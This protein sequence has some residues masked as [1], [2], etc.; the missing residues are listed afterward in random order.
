MT[1]RQDWTIMNA[2]APEVVV[3]SGFSAPLPPPLFVP[4]PLPPPCSVPLVTGGGCDSSPPAFGG[5]TT[6]LGFLFAELQTIK[7]KAKTSR[8]LK[9]NFFILLTDSSFNVPTHH[10]LCN[11]SDRNDNPATHQWLLK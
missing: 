8:V 1:S 2:E 7:T 5:S 11:V 6:F 4:L 9:M 3:A 10:S